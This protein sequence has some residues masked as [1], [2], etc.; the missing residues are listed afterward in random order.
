MP[1]DDFL[2]RALGS[3]HATV[4]L[5]LRDDR[6]S[7]RQREF[8]T[9]AA[10]VLA[11][12]RVDVA[13]GP[14]LAEFRAHATEVGRSLDTRIADPKF[15]QELTHPGSA[16]AAWFGKAVGA[17]RRFLDA[18]ES[19]VAPPRARAAAATRGPDDLRM[20]LSHYLAE[21]FP[22]LPP[23]PVRSLRVVPGGRGKETSLFEVAPNA[24]MPT[25]LVLRRD[26]SL[27]VTGSSAYA[28]YPLLKAVEALGLP[29]PSPVA[30]EQDPCHLGGS[31]LIVTE[32]IDAG[33]GGELFAELN[34]LATLHESF[35]TDLIGALAK[36]HGLHEHPSGTA[37]A[38]H[39]T[40]STDPLE[41]VRGFQHLFRGIT[42]KPPLH[43]ATE[44]G[45]AWLLANPPRGG[46]PRRLVHGDVGLHNVLVRDGKLAAI[47]D[48]ELA[49]LGDPAEDI[50]YAWSPL[51]RHLVP[52]QRLRQVYLQHG[53][54]AES[55]DAHAI[56]W[57]GVWAHTRNSVYTAMHYDW[58]A[59]GERQDVECFNAGIDFFARTQLYIARE[60]DEAMAYVKE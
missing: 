18:R 3:V 28:E 10:R 31:F 33:L 60:L 1:I 53:G 19:A 34:D 43:V 27:S 54:D 16:S 5:D 58:A 44:L 37:L 57:Y 52:W 7:S 40:G 4:A 14:M 39:A 2:A 45:F 9:C 21:R 36:L 22:A 41:M 23:D 50:A 25:H 32:V 48:W 55:L 46:R 20:R 8:A 35:A 24:V 17:T 6:Q 30:A 12:L 42:C 13:E 38:G 59:R 51:L 29:V 49:H 47:L 56:A 11:R 15:L 26:L